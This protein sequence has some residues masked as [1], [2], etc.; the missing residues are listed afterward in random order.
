MKIIHTSDWHLGNRLADYDRQH[1][2]RNFLNWLTERIRD[3]R[4]EVLLVSGDIF[5]SP[6]PSDTAQQIYCEFLS[7][8]ESAG[9]RQVILTAG[10]H[11]GIANLKVVKPL[12]ERHGARLV[13]SLSHGEESECLIPVTGENG[14]EVLVCAVPFLRVRDVSLSADVNDEEARRT[15]YIRGVAKIYES[16]GTL[17]EEW[18]AAH[19]GARVIA[20]GHLAVSGSICG[21]GVRRQIGTLDECAAGI[22]PAAFDY[23]AL[24]HIHKGYSPEKG[25]VCYC[26]S[27]LPLADDETKETHR[28][29]VLDTADMSKRNLEVPRFVCYE[30]RRCESPEHLQEILT[31]LKATSEKNDNAP[32]VLRLE[33]PS[34]GISRQEIENE[35][36]TDERKAFIAR[37]Q[38]KFDYKHLMALQEEE[39]N[40][41]QDLTPKEVFQLKLDAEENI[42]EGEKATLSNLFLTILNKIN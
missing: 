30:K 22:F 27:P 34:S 41:L 2:F 36:E 3:E 24:G 13:I 28:I 10:N 16:V 32:V 9:C 38:I 11:D 42:T 1:E 12:L 6:T 5:D 18:K 39:A 7:Q 20:M 19:P 33:C 37:Y 17:A 26:G 23:V 14:E 15:A 21:E 35:L 25:R 8:V 4:A 29:C 40:S 31:E